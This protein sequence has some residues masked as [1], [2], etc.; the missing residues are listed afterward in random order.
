MGSA[1]WAFSCGT[2]TPGR[3]Q[4]LLA[5]RC[6]QPEE[7]LR[8]GQFIFTRDAKAAMAGRLMIRKVIAEKLKIQWDEIVLKRTAKGKPF[9][10]ND[11]RSSFPAFNFNVSHQ[12]NYA[13]LAAESGLQ[14]GIDV[15]KTDF[16]GSGSIE[17]FFRI[18]NRQFTDTEWKSIKSME[19]E[20]TQLDTF[21]RHWA[22][23]E[24]FIKAIGIGVGFNLQRIEFHASPLHMEVGKLYKETKMLLDGVEEEGWLFEE[25]RLDDLHHVAVA[26]G[27]PDGF[28]DH[29]CNLMHEGDADRI[30]KQFTLLSFDDLVASA[31]PMYPE[32]P[33]YWESFISKQETPSR[34][35]AH[36]T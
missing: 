15:M 21:Y 2:W 1:R 34:Q 17:E 6:V 16:P 3:A 36:S 4:W 28:G 12:G 35:G 32:D 18:M 10:L 27:R 33:P 13:V 9:L 31:V 24:S 11:Y 29:H 22:L 25:T 8:I 7:K 5:A 26:I 19:S 20:W 14:V 30:K 23:K